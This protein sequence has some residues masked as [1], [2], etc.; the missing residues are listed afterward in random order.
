MAP[1][2]VRP[3][4]LGRVLEHGHGSR[5]IARVGGAALPA[6]RVDAPGEFERGLAKVGDRVQRYDVALVAV[7][8]GAA[9]V[10]VRRRSEVEALWWVVA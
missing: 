7:G 4:L 1:L 5:E 9:R 8:R 6:T 3:T 2:A 10:E